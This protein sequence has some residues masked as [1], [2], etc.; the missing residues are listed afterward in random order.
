MVPDLGP[1]LP[2][3]VFLKTALLEAVIDSGRAVADVFPL[4]AHWMW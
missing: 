2:G 4:T 3:E 1:L